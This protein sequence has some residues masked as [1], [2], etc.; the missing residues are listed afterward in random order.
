MTESLLMGLC[1]LGLAQTWAWVVARGAPNPWGP[2]IVL[3][4]A[5]LTRYEAWPITAVAMMFA[6]G[7]LVR[8]GVS[9]Q[10]AV[11][12]VGI[13][14]M[15]PAAAILGFM[16]LSRVT[17]GSWLVYNGFF[18]IDQ[19]M[20]HQPQAVVGAVWTGVYRLNGRLMTLLAA[21]GLITLL[22]SIVRARARSHLLIVFAL[23]GCVALPL[24]AFWSG[25][26][27]RIRYLVPLTMS[28]AAFVGIGVGLLPRFRV[29]ATMIVVLTALIE[30]P[31]LSASRY[32]PM[33][34]EATRDAESVL[35]RRGVTKCLL[36]HYDQT[37]ILASMGS[38]AHYMQETARAGISIRQ[39]LHEG[40]GPLW[41]ESLVEAGR[42]V[43]WVLIE[44][45]AEGGDVL[46]QRSRESPEF[47][48]GFTRQCEGGGVALYRRSSAI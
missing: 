8:L 48:A 30:T 4:L 46:A 14:G 18:E 10:V 6:L 20:Y 9:A 26:P 27:F 17:V 3:A 47:L 13:F 23:A 15:F 2:G 37:P 45:Q 32:S 5:C 1:L 43:S 28:V 34:V 31:P 42:H 16:V 12:R 40:I 21:F 25:H 36:Q 33:V 7:A 44:E 29:L 41:A 24:Y 19:S 39:F 35:A 11:R 22:T 38:L